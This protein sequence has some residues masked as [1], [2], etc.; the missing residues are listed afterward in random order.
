MQYRAAASRRVLVLSYCT[1][2]NVCSCNCTVHTGK[3]TVGPH[4]SNTAVCVRNGQQKR[5]AQASPFLSSWG[6]IYT[7][8][9]ITPGQSEVQTLTCHETRR[10]TASSAF[11]GVV[12]GIHSRHLETATPTKETHQHNNSQHTSTS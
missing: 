9:L 12:P 5:R 2:S 1:T 4:I 3:Q 6:E 10:N 7:T 11:Q 8:S